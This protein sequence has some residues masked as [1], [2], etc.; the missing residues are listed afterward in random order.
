MKKWKG[1]E[2]EFKFNLLLA[3]GEGI[4]EPP[5]AG[6]AGDPPG[7]GTLKALRKLVL[8]DGHG[9]S[10]AVELFIFGGSRSLALRF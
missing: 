5:G 10:L 6:G 7:H 4:S 8:L 1:F 9:Q 2:D 3:I